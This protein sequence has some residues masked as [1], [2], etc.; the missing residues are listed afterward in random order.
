MNEQAFN[1]SMRIIWGSH[2]SDIT[3][4]WRLSAYLYALEDTNAELHYIEVVKFM[5]ALVSAK[6]NGEIE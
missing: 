4:L 3:R 6:I 1:V 2:N 5:L